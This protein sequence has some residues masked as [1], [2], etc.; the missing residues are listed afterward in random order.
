[1]LGVAMCYYLLK[2]KAKIKNPWL[3]V[4][5]MRPG[6]PG[7]IAK[8]HQ[9]TGAGSFRTMMERALVVGKK[10]AVLPSIGIGG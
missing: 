8:D 6:A 10:V 3:L 2:S 7:L 9:A 5:A 4:R 1:M